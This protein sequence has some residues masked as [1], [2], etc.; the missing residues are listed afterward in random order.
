M[1]DRLSM[2]LAMVNQT[3]ELPEVP[4]NLYN[5]L[6]GKLR[7]VDATTAFASMWL[8]WL[9]WDQRWSFHAYFLREFDLACQFIRLTASEIAN[10]AQAQSWLLLWLVYSSLCRLGMG[11]ELPFQCYRFSR[12]LPM[13]LKDWPA[14][15]LQR[16]R[17][18]L[19]SQVLALS[20]GL[21]RR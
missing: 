11:E 20:E 18:G 15:E 10:A 17:E 13:L 6:D 2:F 7:A 14:S 5:R 21:D 12:N 1:T 8:C 19:E 3:G 16:S 9:S 4:A